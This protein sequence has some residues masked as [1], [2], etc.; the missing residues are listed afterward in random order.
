MSPQGLPVLLVQGP[1]FEKQGFKT[2]QSDHWKERQGNKPQEKSNGVL[3]GPGQQGS[4]G[5]RPQIQS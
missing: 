1:Y 2:Y 4:V 3:P 5:E